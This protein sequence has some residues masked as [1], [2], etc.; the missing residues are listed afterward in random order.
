MVSSSWSF[1]SLN[2]AMARSVSVAPS[3]QDAHRPW[4]VAAPPGQRCVLEAAPTTS[5]GALGASDSSVWN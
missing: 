5:S 1:Q 2:R 4:C 3:Q